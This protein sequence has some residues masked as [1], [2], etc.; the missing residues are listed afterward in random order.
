MPDP[1]TILFLF[2]SLGFVLLPWMNYTSKEPLSRWDRFVTSCTLALPIALGC[3][4]LS[5]AFFFILTL[6]SVTTSLDGALPL[7]L[8]LPWIGII[9]IK[10]RNYANH[11]K[12]EQGS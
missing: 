10:F 3:I 11:K 7:A 8:I 12:A 6:L 5:A 4:T 1:A 9:W 2:L